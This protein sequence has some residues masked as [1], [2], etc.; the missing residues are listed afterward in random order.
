MSETDKPNPKSS[1]GAWRLKI[2][3]AFTFSG[4]LHVGAGG[5]LEIATDS[6][7]VTA[8]NGQPVL[9]GSSIRGVLRHWAE[10]EMNACN[11]DQS[12]FDSLF[13]ATQ[14]A[15]NQGRLSVYSATLKLPD[16][17]QEIR[18]HICLDPQTEA[19]KKGGKFDQAVALPSSGSFVM[20][21]EGDGKGDP[22]LILL[23]AVCEALQADILS[24]GAKSGIGLGWM[25][26]V[27]LNYQVYERKIPEGLSAYLLERLNN[28]DASQKQE[29]PQADK[30]QP[31]EDTKE[32]QEFWRNP[33][34]ETGTEP[35]TTSLTQEQR[36]NFLKPLNW[37][38]LDLALQFN[39]PMLVGGLFRGDR[40]TGALARETAEDSW[41]TR[42]NGAAYL[43]GSALR[44]VLSTQARRIANTLNQAEIF[45]T[46]FGFVKAGKS[47]GEQAQKGLLS[48][49][50]GVLGGN[51]QP[52]FMNHV[53]ID[54]ISGFASDGALFNVAALGSPCF[55]IS[56]RCFWEHD[57]HI[58]QAAVA[59]LL[60]VLRDLADGQLWLGANTTAGYG[61]IQK[62]QWKA[63][64]GSYLT[65]SQ[66]N[67]YSRKSITLDLATSETTISPLQAIVD[68]DP[69]KGV[70]ESWQ[71][72]VN[73]E[74]REAEHVSAR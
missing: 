44:G 73:Q 69:F 46:L 52:I 8:H 7:I 58:Q 50:E 54:R 4:A 14:N 39:G 12:V 27:K 51:A 10:R 41:I 2:K 19:V 59:L 45:E 20:L 72:L 66:E 18:D 24:F 30:T 55:N 34:S 38:K 37:F 70:M 71:G 33:T 68:A 60:F 36:K 17:A 43:P 47:G 32:H 61:H 26:E 62:V 40:G 16:Q 64:K 49:S 21:Y 56:L 67:G 74:V 13:G 5:N 35:K 3:V 9:P 31:K 23:K 57:N 29:Q 53:A 63:L 25:Q 11:Q 65:V 15:D 6:P 28:T 22:E 42:P 48:V 1:R